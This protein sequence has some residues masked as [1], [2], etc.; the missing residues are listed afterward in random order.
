MK[1]RT[2]CLVAAVTL[3]GLAA[4]ELGAAPAADQIHTAEKQP[5][6]K[7]DVTEGEWTEQAKNRKTQELKQDLAEQIQHIEAEELARYWQKPRPDYPDQY[8]A[9]LRNQPEA[10]AAIG[11][12]RQDV[13][14]LPA[15]QQD[16]AELESPIVWPRDRR[17][18]RTPLL[19]MAGTR[20]P[21]EVR[22]RLRN[23]I[24]D[25]L[26]DRRHW[27]RR[28]NH[29]RRVE[30]ERQRKARREYEQRVAARIKELCEAPG[31][32]F[33][34]E[35]NRIEGLI[36]KNE[37]VAD[38]LDKHGYADKAQQRRARAGELRLELRTLAER[39]FK[40]LKKEAPAKEEQQKQ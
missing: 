3:A 7:G 8:S 32:R 35:Y 29:W 18:R 27:N 34:I 14:L 2:F 23:Q 4:S 20:S 33:I 38:L 36:K 16:L 9:T 1:Q 37:G 12:L 11:W 31:Y 30:R 40:E 19:L 15:L 6:S 24:N 28:E 5:T 39:Y 10:A 26:A 13:G 21:R 25:I 17:R 22:T